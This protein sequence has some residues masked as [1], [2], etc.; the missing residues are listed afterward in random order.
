[1]KLLFKLMIPLL[2]IYSMSC[3]DNN[4]KNE[5]KVVN[6]QIRNFK[7]QKIDC[8]FYGKDFVDSVI[9]FNNDTLKI[10]AYTSCFGDYIIRDTI[11]YTDTIINLHQDRI[12]NIFIKDSNHKIS[13]IFGKNDIKDLYKD[14]LTFNKSILARPFIEGI[15]FN[16][17]K[18]YFSI[19]FCYPQNLEGDFGERIKFSVD[20][21]GKIQGKDVFIEEE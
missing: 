21:N 3:N 19:F 2:G 4:S 7:E 9:L 16:N 13:T 10:S 6:T 5:K 15:D 8:N 18:V 17:R 12:L 20:F 11:F 14:N 1:M